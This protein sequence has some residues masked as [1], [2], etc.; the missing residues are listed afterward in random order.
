MDPA[1]SFCSKIRFW[2]F[3]SNFPID[4]TTCSSNTLACVDYEGLA[5]ITHML[6]KKPQ[7]GTLGNFNL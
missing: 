7:G 1:L 5:F 2:E 6:F 4:L 3:T